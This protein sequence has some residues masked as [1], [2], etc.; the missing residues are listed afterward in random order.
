MAA[1]RKLTDDQVRYIR[2]CARIRKETP[3]QAQLARRFR[4]RPSAIAHAAL[5]QTHKAVR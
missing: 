2:D 5:G 4:V 3:T 1:P